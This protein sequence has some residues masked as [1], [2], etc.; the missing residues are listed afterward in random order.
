A[1]KQLAL[2]PLCQ[3]DQQ[4]KSKSNKSSGL[5]APKS[6]AAPGSKPTSAAPKGSFLPGPAPKSAAPPSTQDTAKSSTAVAG[7]GA[8][9]PKGPSAPASGPPPSGP[10]SN[11]PDLFPPSIPGKT[12][13]RGGSALPPPSTAKS[14]AAPAHSGP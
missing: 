4:D 11:Q 7:P 13:A 8:N 14:S 10:G 9:D 2:L 1:S 5:P 3:M 12:S 6:A